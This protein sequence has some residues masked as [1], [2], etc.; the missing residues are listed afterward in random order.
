MINLDN[1]KIIR[2]FKRLKSRIQDDE[3][4]ALGAQ[5]TYY[6]I[7]AFFPFLIFLLTILSHTSLSSADIMLRLSTI[8]P[9][10][11]FELVSGTIND[12]IE[13]GSTSLLSFG[14]IG[15]LWTASNGVAA[16]IKGLNKAYDQS[17]N[18]SFFKLRGF[19]IL[20][21][22]FLS[23]GI[24]LALVLLVFGEILGNYIFSI[25]GLSDIFK[26]FW[27]FVRLLSPVFLLIIVFILF[28][29]YAPNKRLHFKEVL[30][31]SIF[32]TSAW[33]IISLLF[34]YYINNFGNYTKTYGSLGGIIILLIWL[35]ISSIIIL[36]GGELNATL[37]FDRKTFKRR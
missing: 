22:I 34:S 7:L 4:P 5:L 10:Q 26:V 32:T 36:I 23:L 8:I 19:A 17:E 31:G 28:Y 11:S 33:I 20:I 24:V 37:A 14:I 2:L 1:K 30:P 29:K 21:T 12:V 9:D 25:F 13:N 27:G 3:V 15:T 18:R 6:L 16:I 35:Y